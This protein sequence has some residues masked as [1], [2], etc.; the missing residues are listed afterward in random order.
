MTAT[1]PVI[2]TPAF[3]AA[4]TDATIA[5]AARIRAL[6]SAPGGEGGDDQAAALASG[7]IAGLLRHG[8]RPTAARP[9][10]DWHPPRRRQPPDVA[11]RGAASA[12]ELLGHASHDTAE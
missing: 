9:L 5:L 12:R 7:Y 3:A 6:P 1:R 11:R 2:V 4:I 8:W 10:P